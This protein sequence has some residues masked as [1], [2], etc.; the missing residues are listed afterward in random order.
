MSQKGIDAFIVYSADPHMSE[1]LPEEWL[2]RE[3]LSGFT[4]S[5]G[6]VVIT[7]NKAALWT[8]SR[9]FVQ[10]PIELKGSGIDLMKD[11][12]EGTPDYIDWIM[13]EIPS[14]GKVGVNALATSHKNWNSLKEKFEKKDI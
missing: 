14:S 3:W 13:E 2:E 8:D 11:G 5:A 7:K 9:Y 6:F 10:A 4:G 12:E 1:Y